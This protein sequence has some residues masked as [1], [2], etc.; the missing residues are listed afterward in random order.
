MNKIEMGIIAAVLVILALAFFFLP[1]HQEDSPG[2]EP[3]PG[4]SAAAN[5]GFTY[6]PVTPRVS[7][8][9]NLGVDSGAMVTEVTPRGPA[10]RA[11]VKVGD[12]ILSFN[13]DRLEEEPLL[14]LMMACYS[15]QAIAMEVRRG[16]NI[17]IIE[18]NHIGR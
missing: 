3:M 5:L 9:Y 8:Y 12:V 2:S 6:L 18:L 17:D 14:G 13:G 7:A 10:D 1:G 4:T 15:D 16:E 11:G